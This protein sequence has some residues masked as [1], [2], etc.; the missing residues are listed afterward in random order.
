MVE[1]EALLF[2]IGN[3]YGKCSEPLAFQNLP[4]VQ[5]ALNPP[6]ANKISSIPHE[7][8]LVKDFH[9]IV[10]DFRYIPYCLN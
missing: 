6:I 8:Y 5:L 10:N 2:N 3:T 9:M 4:R 7:L 1:E